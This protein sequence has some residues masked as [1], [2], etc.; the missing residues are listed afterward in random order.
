MFTFLQSSSVLHNISKVIS[1]GSQIV[2]TISKQQI[3]P[4]QFV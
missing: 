4:N 2:S 3:L 1:K